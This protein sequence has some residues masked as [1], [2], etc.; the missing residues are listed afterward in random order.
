[1]ENNQDQA[2]PHSDRRSPMRSAY[3]ANRAALYCHSREAAKFF[4]GSDKQ[5]EETAQSRGEAEAPSRPRSGAEAP[6]RP[7]SAAT[8]TA[9][10]N[11]RRT[12]TRI[13]E[14]R[15]AGGALLLQSR[16]GDFL[17]GKRW[18]AEG[19]TATRAGASSRSR[20]AAT[21]AAAHHDRRPPMTVST[22]WSGRWVMSTAAEGRNS[23]RE[24]SPVGRLG[25]CG[26]GGLLR[27]V[28]AEQGCHRLFLVGGISREPAVPN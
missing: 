1:M 2:A 26:A 22:G 16:S 6:S 19:T 13:E 5:P 9:T 23:L 12:P 28:G 21:R 8:R 10:H 14:Q 17:L 11:N 3:S 24:A 25:G 15:G 18:K 20:S 7:R 27:V 4:T